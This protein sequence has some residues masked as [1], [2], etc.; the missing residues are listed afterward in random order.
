MESFVLLRDSKGLEY[1]LRKHEG[2]GGNLKSRSRDSITTD[3]I[4]VN[5]CDITSCKAIF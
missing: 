5:N 4:M 2:G 1:E 3:L